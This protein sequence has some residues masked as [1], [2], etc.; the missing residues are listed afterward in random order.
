MPAAPRPA[1]LVLT[2]AI[3][4][5]TAAQPAVAPGA[6]VRAGS[7]SAEVNP[8]PWRFVVQ[9]EG[10]PLLRQAGGRGTVLGLTAPRHFPA[11]P[12]VKGGDMVKPQLDAD[13][14]DSVK[15]H[16]RRDFVQLRGEQTVGEA[17]ASIRERQPE[18]RNIYFYVLDDE[19]RVQGVIPTRRLLLNA[20]DKRLADIMVKPVITIPQTATVLEACE[21][22]TLHRL[23]A[24]RI[25]LVSQGIRESV[26]AR[27]RKRCVTVYNGI[28]PPSRPAGRDR[29]E[30]LAGLKA[31]VPDPA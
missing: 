23:L 30:L 19:G 29:R 8:S 17:L 21:F 14:G 5:V 20:L 25:V 24:D 1:H 22:F 26:P 18:G 27:F 28:D 9:R 31:P 15:Q 2:L 4:G 16:L 10:K 7:V 11:M 13:L 3:L 12:M 6:T